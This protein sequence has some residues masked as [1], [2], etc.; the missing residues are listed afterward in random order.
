VQADVYNKSSEADHMQLVLDMGTT[1][2]G[3]TEEKH[4]ELIDKKWI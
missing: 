1:R 4:Q 2:F 3:L